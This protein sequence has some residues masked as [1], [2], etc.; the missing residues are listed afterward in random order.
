M[1][2][3]FLTGLKTRP[4]AGYEPP[5]GRVRAQTVAAGML[6][7][8][9][10]LLGACPVR[11]AHAGELQAEQ[12]RVW[13]FQ[14]SEDRNSDQWPDG[15]RRR[16]GRQYPGFIPIRMTP[17]DAELAEMA[18][19]TERI[20]S[21]AWHAYRQGRLPA[22]IVLEKTL[23]P[24]AAFMDRWVVDHCLQIDMNG[25][26]VEM[27]SPPFALDPRYAYCLDASL[28][29]TNL[30]SH[31]AR[32]ELI[33]F[34]HGGQRLN[35]VAT[36]DVQ[37]TTDWRNFATQAFAHEQLATAQV[38]IHVEPL[39]A[40]AVSGTVRVDGI[41]IYRMPKLEL[42]VNLPNHVGQ[43]NQTFQIRCTALGV[44]D[45]GSLVN[46]KLLDFSGQEVAR[47]AAT[48]QP[49]SPAHST[50]P[51]THPSQPI[52]P[53]SGGRSQPELP[54][55]S[56]PRGISRSGSRYVSR[57]TP[58][59]PDN[60]DAATERLA[61]AQRS[62]DAARVDAVA[63]WS[64][65]IAEPGFYRVAVD[66]GRSAHRTQ[67]REITLA[68]AEPETLGTGGPFGWSLPD[69]SAAFQP[70]D[71]PGLVEAGGV[72]FIKVPVW[73]DGADTPTATRLA[74]LLERLDHRQ[75]LCIGRLEQAPGRGPATAPPPAATVFANPEIWEPQLEP[76]LTRMSL[77]LVW[78]QL[79]RDDD[80]SFIGNSRL[81]PLLTDIRNRMQSYS[82]ELQLALAWD[83]QDALPDQ[84]QLPW[85]AS[86]MSAQPPL[87]AGELHSHLQQAHQ[88]GQPVWVTL[89]PLPASAYSLLDR[90]RD[91][92]ERMLVVKQTGAAAA[93][94]TT[95]LDSDT[96]LFTPEGAAGEMLLPWRILNRHL[97]QADYLGSVQLPGGSV[98]HVLARGA[99][100]TMIV[101]NDRPVVEQ[102]YLG[103]D[104]KIIDLWGREAAAT[105]L[106]SAPGRV[107]QKVTVG[108][109]PLIIT[110]VNVPVAKWRMGLK[111][112]MPQIG[113]Q[114]LSRPEAQLQLRN[115]FPQ[116]VQ[117]VIHIDAPTLLRSEQKPVRF[118]AG[119]GDNPRLLVP[120]A[121]RSDAS[122]GKHPIRFDFNV[123]AEKDMVFSAYDSLTLG[124]EEVEITWDAVL[125][126]AGNLSLHMTM[127]NKSENSVSFDCKLFP[128]NQPYRRFQIASAPPG[129]SVREMNFPFGAQAEGATLWIRCEE[130]STG[131]Q[132]NYSVPIRRE[133]P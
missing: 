54:P 93:F 82:Q 22:D 27:E 78:F 47:K 70:E 26:A 34:D 131:Q 20:L 3:R 31:R 101:W 113:W 120:L 132:L 72:G 40:R 7:I 96:G 71:V 109:W 18:R 104:V 41:R 59:Q 43:P 5:G 73:F 118:Q 60:P 12:I 68:I 38:V 10:G 50:S 122:A 53:A 90:C 25:G 106:R 30:S 88:Q 17:R 44:R 114:T 89:N 97:A 110:G 35:Q 119:T 45:A 36:T 74:W 14:R 52:A 23:E 128:P 75:I 69:F 16:T 85:R 87:T 56:A 77:K 57:G 61:T 103:D 13:E 24:V 86:Q 79:G 133:Q 95:P 112:A 92:T 129:H 6:C 42:Q 124:I 130:K 127:L 98:N 63:T 105:E 100:G 65:Q 94:V 123:T 28:A 84:K 121:L 2:L 111:L 19:V 102:L 51:T 107:E 48:F 62:D 4:Q 8:A 83:W 32:V 1:F 33:F 108:P 9:A 49:L 125:D 46:F 76:V 80:L 67:T 91:L 66:L 117:G 64:L 126:T 81:I 39:H 115:P 116:T 21:R 99:D 15:W 37:G 55:A 29:T 58:G 11:L